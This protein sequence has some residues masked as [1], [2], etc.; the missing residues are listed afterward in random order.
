VKN[1]NPRNSEK[2]HFLATLLTGLKK[3]VKV[4]WTT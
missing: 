1:L 4:D 3:S 2:A